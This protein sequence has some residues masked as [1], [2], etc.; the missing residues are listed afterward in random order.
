MKTQAICTSENTWG[1]FGG[2][3]NEA[4]YDLSV[5][6]PAASVVA[7]HD[8][9]EPAVIKTIKNIIA[10]NEIVSILKKAS[11]LLDSILARKSQASK[12]S[13]SPGRLTYAQYVQLKKSFKA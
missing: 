5:S 1:A 11:C 13:Q 2:V 9:K 10:D 8:H 6:G 12:R 4:T 3:A 7:T